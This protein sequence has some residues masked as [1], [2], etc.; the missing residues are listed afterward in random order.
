MTEKIRDLRIVFES[1]V[2]YH[3]LWRVFLLLP[4]VWR[5]A[6]DFSY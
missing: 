5:I 6:S 4:L 2:S 1:L 3:L